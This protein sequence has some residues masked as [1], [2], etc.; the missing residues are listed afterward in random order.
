MKKPLLTALFL[1]LFLIPVLS[2][3]AGNT[4][5]PQQGLVPCGNPGQPD[6]TLGHF[7]QM[8][9]IIYNFITLWIAA[10]LAILMISIGGVMMLISG[11]NP[12]MFGLGKK[13]FWLSIIGLVLVLASY[14]II[15]F[16][17]T[18]LGYVYEF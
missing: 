12:Q 16:I 4:F 5:N 9:G 7:F 14:L 15:K 2:L 13:I 6:C 18:T 17:L 1:V 10:P 3:A 11:G 8:L